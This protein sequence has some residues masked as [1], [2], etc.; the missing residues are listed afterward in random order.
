MK[1]K[2]E[3]LFPP[4]FCDFLML[5]SRQSDGSFKISQ[6]SGCKFSNE[7]TEFSG[8]IRASLTR[9][10]YARIPVGNHTIL[11][12]DILVKGAVFAHAQKGKEGEDILDKF[13]RSSFRV[14]SVSFCANHIYVKG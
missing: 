10:F 4:T 14:K 3:G 2:T 5:Y 13:P 8:D 12:G 6:I 1:S 9:N 11:P 7:K